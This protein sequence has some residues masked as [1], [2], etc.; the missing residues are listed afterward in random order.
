M[1]FDEK[2]AKEVIEKYGLSEKTLTVWRKRN[3]I[4]NKYFDSNYVKKEAIT[5]KPELILQ[6]RI[7]LLIKSKKIE[8]V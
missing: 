1:I 6:N 4:P 2:K 7:S 5:S 8:Y 3:T